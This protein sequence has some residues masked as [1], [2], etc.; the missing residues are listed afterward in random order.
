MGCTESKPHNFK[1]PEELKE[2]KEQEI[3]Q[4]KSDELLRMDLQYLENVENLPN[5]TLEK[6]KP[7]IKRKWKWETKSFIPLIN[8]KRKKL[9]TIVDSSLFDYLSIINLNKNRYGILYELFFMDVYDLQTNTYIFRIKPI[10]GG[11]KIVLINLIDGT[12]L[13]LGDNKNYIISIIDNKG[14]QIHYELGI[15]GLR[16]QLCD[17]RL[18]SAFNGR[19]NL[20]EK[21]Q[22]GIFKLTIEKFCS[23]NISY[24]K[25]VRDNL[26]ISRNENGIYFFDI[27]TLEIIE[28][29][30][31]ECWK[32]YL[33]P[34]GMVNEN[35]CVIK[36]NH[37]RNEYA[38]VDIIGKRIIEYASEDEENYE[39]YLKEHP[40][41][42]PTRSLLID[43]I[44][45]L[46]DHSL[47][48]RL[49]N[50][51]LHGNSLNQIRWIEEKGK[52]YEYGNLGIRDDYGRFL[53]E[54]IL[55]SFETGEIF[56]EIGNDIFLL[57]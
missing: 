16:L 19:L 4:K 10:D 13:F 56:M 7:A 18:F 29:I 9:K 25:Q 8:K 45:E 52:I 2:N 26:M 15:K 21:D 36:S 1:D 48:L 54:I 55:N 5:I 41:E 34:F 44:S 3:K 30:K 50:Q 38:L 32:E 24:F 37:L 53:D 27:N 23:P 12:F 20:Y 47:G 22:N 40:N 17:E 39:L 42:F 57:K 6:T 51:Y 11:E 31:Y 46:P 33:T 35:L 49:F 14:Y 43:D 28:T